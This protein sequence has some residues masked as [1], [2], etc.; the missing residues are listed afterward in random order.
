MHY[1]NILKKSFFYLKLH[2]DILQI[3]FFIIQMNALV[4]SLHCL[5]FFDDFINRAH[6]QSN[7]IIFYA[8]QQDFDETVLS[9]TAEWI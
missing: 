7:I 5:A 4:S 9:G 6:E 2:S 8:I 3:S 1:N